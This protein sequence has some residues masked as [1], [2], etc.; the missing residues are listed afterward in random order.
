[1][2]KKLSKISLGDFLAVVGLILLT[3]LHLYL[4]SKTFYIDP[5]GNF[6]TAAA[7]YGD[8]PLHLTQI[9]KFAFTKWNLLDPIYAGARL[10]Y[11]FILSLI[12][13]VILKAT[14]SWSFS[15]LGPVYF[16]ATANIVLLFIIY[17]KILKK[18]LWIFLAIFVFLF[19]GGMGGYRYIVDAITNHQSLN[20]FLTMLVDKTISTISKWD[21]IYPNQNLDYGSPI[22]LVFLHQRTFFLG[23]FGFLIF[24]W[25]LFKLYEKAKLRHAIWAG[26]I[27]GLLPLW[28]THA[29]VAAVIVAVVTLIVALFEN[30]IALAKLIG[31]AAGIGLVISLPQLWYLMSSKNTLAA[32]ASFLALRLGWMVAPTI[33]SV[34][35]GSSNH[36]IFS[37]AYLKFLWVNFGLILPMFIAA[38]ILVKKNI[39]L[40][41]S[42]CGGLALLLAVMLVRFQPWDYDTNKILVYFQVLAAPAIVYL[43]MKIYERFKIIGAVVVVVSS[44]LLLYSGLLDNLPRLLVSK[45][46]TPVIFD[47][48]AQKMAE[49]IKTN[50]PENDQILTGNSHLNLVSSLCGRE[51]LE[52]YPG[53][54]WTRGID[55]G[56]REAEI[57]SFYANPTLADQIIAKYSIKYVLLDSSVKYDFGA[58]QTIF[59]QTFHKI[60]EIGN[61]SLYR[62]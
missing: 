12:C 45:Q 34:T 33:G 50:I 55:Y 18:S 2:L 5:S 9:S 53:W 23:L 43:L 29:F 13:G 10:Q 41:I 59:D 3:A 57:K 16:L 42:F 15:V 48:N 26:V 21:A 47:T 62:I 35:F 27:L 60:Y 24:L 6:R 1:M 28:H 25:L 40:K 31:L 17:K 11:P 54:L 7:G 37:L 52:G 51:V 8:I 22:S 20:Q 49:Y 61:Y 56:G 32:N 36:T 38:A 4:I 46:S 19:G 44:I 30:K 39:W 58:S 14:G